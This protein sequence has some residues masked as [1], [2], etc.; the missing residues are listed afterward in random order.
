MASARRSRCRSDTLAD[1]A[2]IE[3]LHLDARVHEVHAIV[4]HRVSVDGADAHGCVH[5]RGQL[6]VGACAVIVTEVKDAGDR[7]PITLHSRRLAEVNA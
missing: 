7:Q 1:S 6:R 3:G 4:R 2:F 5:A